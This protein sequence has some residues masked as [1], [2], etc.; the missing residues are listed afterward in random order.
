MT[1]R[2]EMNCQTGEVQEITLTQDEIDAALARKAEEDALNSPDNLAV[3]AVDAVDK[4]WFEINFNQENR[5][6]VLEGKSQ[7]TRVQYRDALI[8]AYKVI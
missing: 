3:R 4:L 7:V 5:I 1:T 8:A 6:R 2:I